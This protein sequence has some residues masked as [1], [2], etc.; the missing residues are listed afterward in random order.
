MQ[1]ID[2][3]RVVHS[4]KT[5]AEPL[6]VEEKGTSADPADTSI[7]CG[8]GARLSLQDAF[9][10][11]RLGTCQGRRPWL[12]DIDPM[13]CKKELKL[14]IRTA[15]YTYLPQK[16]TIISLPVEDDELTRKVAAIVGEMANVQAIE[17]VAAA[18]LFNP[19][20]KVELDG[21][22]DAEIFERLQ[23]LR[24]GTKLDGVG[25]PKLAE[26][27]VFASGRAEIGVNSPDAK[28]YAQ[29]LPREAWT[30]DEAGIGLGGHQEPCRRTSPA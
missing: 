23:R 15:T 30:D 9:Q 6:W 2:W 27:N 5:C 3:R 28:L 18:K 10:P 11:G 21:F 16:L 26:F 19:R 14:L 22:A 12:L 20:I 17:H 1:D 25:P 4:K 7:V 24:S 13:G 29:T 8:C